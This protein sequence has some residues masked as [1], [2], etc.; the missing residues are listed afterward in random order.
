MKILIAEDE[1]AMQKIIAL[2]LQKEGYSVEVAKSG[3]EALEM[4]YEGRFDLVVLDWM[5]P[6]MSGITVCEEMKRLEIPTKILMLTARSETEDEL[7][8]LECGADEYLRKPFDP[9]VLIVRIKKLLPEPEC[10]RCG[11][12]T[13]YPQ[14][15]EVLIGEA[16][17]TLSQKELALLC[18]MIANQGMILSR[19]QL[20]NQVWGIDYEGDDRTLDTHV[21]RLRRKIGERFIH[22]HRGM[23]YALRYENE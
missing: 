2:Y 15:S 7:L 1:L 20:L 4:L 5:M 19:E 14:K 17:V 16:K 11:E 12:L 9:R 18:Y 21:G 22:T 23:G 3:Q 10:I 8:G 13:V 6:E